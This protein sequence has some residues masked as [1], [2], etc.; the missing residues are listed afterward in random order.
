MKDITI[1]GVHIL[2]VA[3]NGATHLHRVETMHTLSTNVYI[4][5][6]RYNMSFRNAAQS[7]LLV[8]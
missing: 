8:H 1:E 3:V 4:C 5:A 6:V 2:L 7:P